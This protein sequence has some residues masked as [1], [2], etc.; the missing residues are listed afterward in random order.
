MFFEP[1]I[2]WTDALIYLLLAVGIAF[3]LYARRHEH[4]LASW[5]KVAHSASGMSALTILLCFVL[6]GLLDT[7]HFRPILEQTAQSDGKQLYS[8]EVLS[9]LDLLTE[10]LRAQTEKTYSAP[11]SAFLYAKETITTPDGNQIRD[12]AR[13]S[14]G[15]AHLNNPQAELSGDVLW[16]SISGISAGLLIWVGLVAGVGFAKARQYRVAFFY[17]QAAI[18]RGATEI[19]WRAILITLAVILATCGAITVLA[20]HY[21]VL[22]TDKVGQDVLY[23]SLKSIRTGLVIGALTTLIMLPFALLLGIGAGYFRGWVDDVIQ[24][25]YTTLSSIP[26]V[27]LIAAAVLMMQVYIETHADMLDT[28]AARADLRLLFLCIILGITS[29]TGLC[30]LLRGETMKL[31]EMEYIQ[32]AHAFGVSHWRIVTRHILP[33]VIHIVLITTVMDFSSLVLAEAVLSYVGVGVDPSTISFG[34]MIN[35]SRLEMAREPM[36]WWTLFASFTFMFALVLSAN[37]FSDAVQNAFNPRNRIMVGNANGLPENQ[38]A[39]KNTEE[40]TK[41]LPIERNTPRT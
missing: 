6:I 31:R 15:G 19:P 1:V 25:V 22:G 4:A 29:W 9:L 41:T 17:M 8:V 40:T 37:L 5:R 32:A 18:W 14:Y 26:S 24:Y 7:V 23:L 12:F 11:L 39:V 10:S 36:V 35:A 28:A 27:L 38:T 34:T 16:R 13:L 20:S 30:R 33:N 21:H 3:A 2:L